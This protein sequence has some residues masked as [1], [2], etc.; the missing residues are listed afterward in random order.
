[1]TTQADVYVDGFLAQKAGY[2]KRGNPFP[3]TRQ[4]DHATWWAGWKRG[5]MVT[6][7]GPLD[8]AAERA[9]IE[10]IAIHGD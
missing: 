8:E 7:P 3:N 10:W 1:M 5:E 4:P 2:D 9:R 6:D